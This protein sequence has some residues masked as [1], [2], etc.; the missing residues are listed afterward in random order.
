[1]ERM[2]E[3]KPGVRPMFPP[4]GQSTAM[5]PV[6]GS[7]YSVA[8]MRFVV[9][10]I[11]LVVLC[12]GW[13]IFEKAIN[14]D[15][16]LHF[17]QIYELADGRLR[18][19]I[20]TLPTRLFG[21][22][23]MVSQ[24]VIAQIQTIRLIML[25]CAVLTAASVTA[26]ARRLVSFEIAVLCGLVYL[27]AGFVFTNAFTFRTDPV[28][29]A[30]LMVAL[31]VFAYGPLSWMRA[32]LIGILVG[33]AGALSIKSIFY[34]PCFAAIAWL[35]WSDPY[36]R[37]LRILSLFLVVLAASIFTFLLLIGL[38]GAGLPASEPQASNLERTVGNFL[39]F[40]EFEQIRYVFAEAIFAPLVTVG[41]L[42]L[43]F[44]AR[45]LPRQTKVLL[46]G[47][48]GP[49][50][51]LLFYRNTF[52]YF[53][54]FLLP[55]VCVAIAPVLARLVARYGH[56]PVVIFALIGPV[57][58]L[59]KEPYGTLERQRAT[60]A[61]VQ[62]LFPEPTPY[63]SY[64]SYIPDYPR[65]FPSLISGVGLRRYW[66][67]R[68]G[69]IARDIKAGRIAFVIATGDA[70][71]AVYNG[72]GSA[73]ILPPRDVAALR[74]NF[75]PYSDTIYILGRT[76][77]P[78]E[79]QQTV[80]IVRG[81]SYSLEGRGLVI[82]GQPLI[83]GTSVVLQAGVHEMKLEGGACVKLWALDQVPTLPDNFP[84]GPI[85]GGF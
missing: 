69:Q 3:G 49:L 44:V 62:R 54:T 36:I 30:A 22:A 81:G 38:H 20:Q 58:L 39:R 84:S 45:K 78:Q 17:G 60:I 46:A 5:E 56:I 35:R 74:E 18:S 79:G 77:C 31:C 61:E 4:V 55:P 53:F 13:L 67:E 34:L 71:D 6:H 42:M 29:A 2:A 73:A 43:P 64:S 47:L 63:L 66:T 16:F 70:L 24:D 37:K 48:C 28:I 80:K 82:D 72:T 57:F 40:F 11:A 19:G 7:A 50:L 1:M 12:Q 26:L 52:P 23:T 25:V 85:A 65:Q 76:V 75:L 27:T 8:R 33:L 10:V 68:N 83:N 59:V 15:E 41:I 14:W 9:A 51:C 21:W 32:A